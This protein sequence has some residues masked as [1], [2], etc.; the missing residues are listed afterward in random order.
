MLLLNDSKS[1]AQEIIRNGRKNTID[2]S[3]LC[4]KLTD[5]ASSN[6]VVKRS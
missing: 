2:I 4:H 3:D 6:I 1:N 5:L